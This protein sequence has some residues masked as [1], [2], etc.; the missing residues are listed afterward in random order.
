MADLNNNVKAEKKEQE[1]EKKQEKK[2]E[3]KVEKL[4]RKLWKEKLK[5][6]QKE[7]EKENRKKANGRLDWDKLDNTAN[8]FPVIADETMTNVYRIA[9]NLT[10]EIIPEKLEMAIEKVLEQIPL[11]RM[12]LR[13]GAFWYYF[14]E[15][16]RPFPG[17]REEYK[18]PGSYIDKHNNNQYMF[19]VTFYKCRIN[20]EVFHALTDGFGGTIFLQEIIYQYLRYVHQ[21]IKEETAGSEYPEIDKIS[22]GIHMDREDSYVKN[23]KKPAKRK[24]S[25]QSGKGLVLKG[26]K[27]APG[28]LGIMHG[29]LSVAE[30]KKVAKEKGITI[31]ELLVG[32]FVYAVYKGYLNGRASKLPIRCCVP[33]NLRPYFDSTTMKNFFAMVSAEFKPEERENEYSFDE[34]MGI[35]HESLQK[36]ITKEHL[37]EILSYN[38]SN[39]MKK[40]LRI[41]PLPIKKLAIG[42][43]YGI[44]ANAT[45]T[46]VTNIGNIK[47]RE[48]YRKYIDKFYV[49]LSVSKGQNMKGTIVSYGDTLTF[50]ISS[51]LTDTSVQKYFFRT[52]K[53]LGVDVAVETNGFG[54]EE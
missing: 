16:L 47:M 32:C 9:V 50:T 35:V 44:S 22:T 26:E 14:E 4:E 38:V 54:A 2:Q 23:F 49:I 10:E 18:V 33:V 36:Q 13:Q 27:L 51:I 31:N 28:N 7:R 1:K 48:P 34:V 25:Y 20:L 52:L 43:V 41:V 45:T 19:R 37:E 17:I 53:Q 46:T 8:L 24:G 29:F 15:N 12:R 6:K 11:F 5:L 3:K 30:L 21:E 42:Y 39:Q 40:I